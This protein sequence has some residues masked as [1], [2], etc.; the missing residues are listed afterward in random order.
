[1]DSTSV[2]RSTINKLDT[3][4]TSID[5]AY[6][7][8][9]MHTQR[10][11]HRTH[12]YKIE[13][14]DTVSPQLSFSSMQHLF[15]FLFDKSVSI[16]AFGSNCCSTRPSV[17]TSKSVKVL[18]EQKIACVFLPSFRLSIFFQTHWTNKAVS[19][20]QKYFKE[21]RVCWECFRNVEQCWL[22]SFAS[23][24]ACTYSQ[25]KCWSFSERAGPSTI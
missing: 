1:M 13:L 6:T 2:L 16:K 17:E 23:Q 10:K 18:R 8:T 21:H 9:H 25:A 15:L 5:M 14:T 12:T 11:L 20:A 22:L 19:L 7:A 3:L 24:R 4:P